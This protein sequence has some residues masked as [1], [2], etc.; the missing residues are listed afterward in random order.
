[1]KSLTRSGSR[2]SGSCDRLA[3]E[4]YGIASR[5][6]RDVDEWRSSHEEAER[7]LAE[8]VADEPELADVLYVTE[9]ELHAS[10][11]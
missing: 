1:M 2:S 9:V 6:S 4:L 11:N 7:V 10:A 8:I 3:V 5:Q